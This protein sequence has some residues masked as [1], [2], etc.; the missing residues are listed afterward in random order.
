MKI[1]ALPALLLLLLLGAVPASAAES[2]TG[3]LG[4]GGEVYLA[5]VVSVSQVF[6]P[7][8]AAGDPLVLA[9]KVLRS[10]EDPEWIRVPESEGVNPNASFFILHEE[11]SDTLF[12]VWEGRIGS[13]PVIQLASY[14][15]GTWSDTSLISEN[16]W[17]LKG[18]PQL[19]ITRESFEVEDED[20]SVRTVQRTLLHIVWWEETAEGDRT[21]YRPLILENGKLR[22][23][24]Q[25]YVL[26]DLAAEA[27][28]IDAE[29][30][31][32]ALIRHP[33]VQVQDGGKAVLVTFADPA[34]RKILVLNIGPLPA[35][36]G[37]LGDDA[38]GYVSGLDPPGPEGETI[39]SFAGKVRAHIVIVGHRY[40]LNPASVQQM[41]DEVLSAVSDSLSE[42]PHMDLRSLAGV[43]RA[44]I[45]IVGARM[46]GETLDQ[47]VP[48][49]A[50]SVIRIG[51]EDEQAPAPISDAPVLV[52]LTVA[53]ELPAPAAGAGKTHLFASPQGRE[54]IL[55][56][57]TATGVQ[58]RKASHG[59][60][61]PVQ[62]MP[63]GPE[64]DLPRALLLLEQSVQPGL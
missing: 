60:W 26:N 58:F 30:P 57:E 45:V 44:H 21:L 36:L 50:T 13:H 42:N 27:V 52:R 51:L 2:R 18:F 1:R 28:A 20:G 10:G 15:D 12:V 54:L 25:A 7:S 33:S 35:G 53:S 61:S 38:Y 22:A 46:S 34:S 5:Q 59:T 23:L 56:W 31:Q 62:D 14:H 49:A 4:T 40:R 39:A 9:L 11:M 37:L 19:A 17:S 3:T 29:T 6:A 16:I 41:A 32:E 43:V 24:G 48:S 64:L 8:Q 55:A 63:T 47:F